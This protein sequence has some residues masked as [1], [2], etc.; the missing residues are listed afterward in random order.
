MPEF[1]AQ[2]K[3]HAGSLGLVDVLEIATSELRHEEYEQNPFEDAD[4]RAYAR[5]RTPT[6]KELFQTSD[7]LIRSTQKEFGDYTHKMLSKV[8]ADLKK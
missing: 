5:V 8:H 4:L 6:G 1:L 3:E 2:V 7:V